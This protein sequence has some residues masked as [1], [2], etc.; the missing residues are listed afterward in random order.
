M[1]LGG[2]SG[3]AYAPHIVTPLDALKARAIAD[4]SEVRITLLLHPFF[5]FSYTL[6]R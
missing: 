5:V 6:D 4:D 2:G 3:W 1:S